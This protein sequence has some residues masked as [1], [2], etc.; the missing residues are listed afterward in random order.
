MFTNFD[1]I[2]ATR[3]T[4][5]RMR[6]RACSVTTLRV[7]LERSLYFSKRR[8][9]PEASYRAASEKVRNHR[10]K[11]A[12]YDCAATPHPVG[13]I[14]AEVLKHSQFSSENIEEKMQIALSEQRL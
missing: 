1:W 5:V 10:L 2:G 14:A 3:W 13:V 11:E 8:G 6:S 9:Q 4:P 7:A 12:L